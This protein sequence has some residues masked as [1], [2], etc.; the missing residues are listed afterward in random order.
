MSVS[1]DTFPLRFVSY[2]LINCG[3]KPIV[4]RIAAT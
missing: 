2:N 4:V 1:I 3:R